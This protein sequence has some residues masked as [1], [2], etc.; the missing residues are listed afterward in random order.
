M[1]ELFSLR[2]VRK[3]IVMASK[4]AGIILI[5]SYAVATRLPI[6]RNLSLLLWMVFTVLLVLAM[7]YLLGRFI[8]DPVSEIC[9][10]AEKMA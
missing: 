7:D 2:T 5:V 6:S 3:K 4:I 9:A 8:S 1:R 10:A